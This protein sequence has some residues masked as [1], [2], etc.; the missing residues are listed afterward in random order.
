MPSETLPSLLSD[1]RDAA[2][3]GDRERVQSVLDA[4]RNEINRVRPEEKASLIRAIQARDRVGLDGDAHATVDDLAKQLASIGIARAGV[5]TTG[6]LF[7][8]GTEEAT[9]ET[10]E[11]TAG[12]LADQEQQ[13]SALADE[14]G[15]ALAEVELDPTVAVVRAD[16]PNRPQPKGGRFEVATT[17]ANVGDAD[18]EG[19]TLAVAGE[20]SVS[21]TSVDVGTL[22]ADGRAS[23]AFA[24]GGGSAG[25]FDLEVRADSDNAGEDAD[26]VT[27]EVLDKAG[28]IAFVDDNLDQ[29][30]ASLPELD[31]PA[32][33][34]QSI[35]SKLENAG[36]KLDDAARFADQGRA[37]QANNMLDA[38]SNILGAALNQLAEYGGGDNGR[39][40]SQGGGTELLMN[41]IEGVID[42]IATAREAEL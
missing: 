26:T 9:P 37:K 28:F 20:L 38:A 7:A 36:A 32:G 42:S 6:A 22:A 17:V 25:E 35:H 21:P 8:A 34:V 5:V 33:L 23:Q 13:L 3:D 16:G 30:L 1:L 18:A 12:E 40:N 27:V 11:R 2:V 24:V 41:S 15:P 19:V 39:A 14:A 29:V 4:I 31:L 10:I